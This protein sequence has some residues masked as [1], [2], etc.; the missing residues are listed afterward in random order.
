MRQ[1]IPRM[2]AFKAMLLLTASA[3]LAAQDQDYYAQIN[4]Q[5]GDNSNVIKIWLGDGWL[6]MDADAQS[7][8]SIIWHGGEAPKFLLLQHSEKR[9]MEWGKEQIDMLSQMMARMPQG[10]V[11]QT[12]EAKEDFDP[13]S[14]IFIETGNHETIGNW[15]AFEVRVQGDVFQDAMLWLTR[16]TK[17]GIVEIFGRMAE[18][19]S[20]FTSLPMMRANA[21][22]QAD[23]HRMQTLAKADG[24]PK[25]AT[26]RVVHVADG[27]TSILTLE[28]VKIGPFDPSLREAPKGYKKMQ[29]PMMRR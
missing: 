21:G 28:E 12:Q 13:A 15:D 1:T 14:I 25:G 24:M 22:P 17:V 8:T 20:S 10:L 27:Q 4:V 23:M 9:Y 6:R 7:G 5:R 3:S 16:E 2:A 18:P 26:I 19:L 29:M 11:K